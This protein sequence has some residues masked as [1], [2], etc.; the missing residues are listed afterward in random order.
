MKIRFRFFIFVPSFFLFYRFF[1][2]S[3]VISACYVYLLMSRCCRCSPCMSVRMCVVSCLL[4]NSIVSNI[5][6]GL[7]NVF[8]G[9]GDQKEILFSI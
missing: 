4:C 5:I 7:D 3:I 2:V 9:E 1:F 6:S 8:C